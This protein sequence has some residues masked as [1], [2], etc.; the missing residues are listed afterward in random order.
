MFVGFGTILSISLL[1]YIGIAALAI[2][3]LRPLI[4]ERGKIE[5]EKLY[6]QFLYKILSNSL[7]IIFLMIV[8]IFIII[9]F[10]PAWTAKL[11]PMDILLITIIPF[12][13]LTHGLMG[14]I[15]LAILDQ[16]K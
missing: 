16:D 7:I 8:F 2:L 11:P 10:I 15:N 14:F 1:G 13:L 6:L 3:A 9:Q 4:L 5:D 12:F